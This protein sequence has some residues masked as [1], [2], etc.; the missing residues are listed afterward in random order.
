MISAYL[1]IGSNIGDRIANLQ[2]A[3]DGL[4]LYKIEVVAISSVYETEPVGGVVQDDFLNLAVSI[5]TTLS[6]YDLLDKIHEIEQKLHRKRLIHWGPRSIDLDILYY[7]NDVFNDERLIVPHPEIKNRQ[8]VLIPLLE[9]ADDELKI[10]V[11]Q[12]LEKTS[13]QNKVIKTNEFGGIK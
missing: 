10:K 13:D 3:I 2:G 11:K 5:K 7:A 4:R 12:M 6:A 9:I 1:S 8:F